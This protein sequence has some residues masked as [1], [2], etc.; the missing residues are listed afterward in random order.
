MSFGAEQEQR[1]ERGFQRG[2]NFAE[3]SS[4]AFVIVSGSVTYTF[5]HAFL[6]CSKCFDVCSV[7]ALS[8]RRMR[9]N[10]NV[11]EGEGKRL[12]GAIGSMKDQP[13]EL[14]KRSNFY[15]YSCCFLEDEQDERSAWTYRVRCTLRECHV[16]TYFC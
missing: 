16:C 13:E 6:R 9:N 1:T 14:I 10:R 7:V 15:K 5:L 2:R 3:L 11:T 4:I 12:G 8:S